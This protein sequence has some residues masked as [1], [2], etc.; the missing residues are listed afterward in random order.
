MFV[1]QRHFRL[2]RSQ[3]EGL[4]SLCWCGWHPYTRGHHNSLSKSILLC[5]SKQEQSWLAFAFPVETLTSVLY[6]SSSNFSI[7]ALRLTRWL[8][9][10]TLKKWM[11]KFHTALFN[12]IHL[13]ANIQLSGKELQKSWRCEGVI[14]FISFTFPLEWIFPSYFTLA[15]GNRSVTRLKLQLLVALLHPR[16]NK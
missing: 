6:W 3:R 11:H 8:L 15:W 4:N 10:W 12:S 16:V 14:F 2:C 7:T 9:Y 1:F 5:L 13:K